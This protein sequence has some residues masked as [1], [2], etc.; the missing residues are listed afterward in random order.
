[1]RNTFGMGY[2]YN[3]AWYE[4]RSRV[5]R[6]WHHAIE[7]TRGLRGQLWYKLMTGERGLARPIHW[8]KVHPPFQ[9]V[10][11]AEGRVKVVSSKSPE[12]LAFIAAEEAREL[13]EMHQQ[14]MVR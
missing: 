13:D 3:K 7:F 1:M 2:S 11:N 12:G 5:D 14:G 4:V 10:V 6:R 8:R 9:C